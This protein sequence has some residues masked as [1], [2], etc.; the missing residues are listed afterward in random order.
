MGDGL[1][2]W[3]VEVEAVAAV[4][5]RLGTAVTTISRSGLSAHLTG[6]AES[7]REPSL[8]F[9]IARDHGI[10]D[11]GVNGDAGG[12]TWIEVA[13]DAG[14]L[15]EWLDGADLPVRVVDGDP[16]GVR[17]MGIGARELRTS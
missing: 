7:M 1:L 5:E 15:R 10:P 8:P 13:G 16:A 12:I 6:V 4:A 11:P 3:A 9:F 2:G 17:A 14:R